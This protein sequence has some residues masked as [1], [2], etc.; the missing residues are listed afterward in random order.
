MS[1]ESLV[2]AGRDGPGSLLPRSDLVI[3]EA[4]PSSQHGELRPV[5][6]AVEELDGA[7]YFAGLEERFGIPPATFDDYLLFRTGARG[8]SIVGRQVVLPAG[9]EPRSIGMS[10]LFLGRDG[11]QLT[12]AAAIH[13][14][15]AALSHT[16][17][18]DRQQVESFIQRREIPLTD[19]RAAHCSEPGAVI[20]RY[21]GA[22]IGLGVYWRAEDG[23]PMLLGMVPRSW[24]DRK[25]GGVRNGAGETAGGTD[26][27]RGG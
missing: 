21:L 4:A 14:G 10:F 25:R 19:A 23:R 3:D 13:F 9:V 2:L 5:G 11:L 20:A 8:L 16:L 18:L 24:P 1:G 27:V 12:T 26:R 22:T 17:D 6:E 7:P 15:R